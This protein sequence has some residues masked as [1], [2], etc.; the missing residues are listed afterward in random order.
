MSWTPRMIWVLTEPYRMLPQKLWSIPSAWPSSWVHTLWAGA[1]EYVTKSSTRAR[2]SLTSIE[3]YKLSIGIHNY[4]GV[5][6]SNMASLLREN[7][8]FPKVCR[9]QKTSSFR[10]RS[11]S[12]VQLSWQLP[13]F[14]DLRQ[15]SSALQHFT[16][17][18]G[19]RPGGPTALSHHYN[20]THERQDIFYIQIFCFYFR[21]NSDFFRKKCLR[22]WASC[23]APKLFDAKNLKSA[24]RKTKKQKVWSSN[25]YRTKHKCCVVFSS[26][27]AH[28][29]RE[30]EA[31]IRLLRRLP[32]KKFIIFWVPNRVDKLVL[33]AWTHYCAYS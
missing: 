6:V 11:F 29:P 25:N 9:M 21:W 1:R 22:G 14:P 23:P 10:K 8:S 19:M 28:F 20:C 13:T 27:S 24:K 33:L 17:G 12:S 15:V 18:F 4:E 5:Q 7:W 26:T 30:C 2:L 16:S 32:S 3:V 31:K